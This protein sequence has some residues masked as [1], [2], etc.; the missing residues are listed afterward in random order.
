MKNAQL[1]DFTQGNITSQLVTFAWPLFLSNLLQVFYNMVDMIIV[2]RV[3]GKAGT[4]AVAVGGDISHFLAFVAM[5][6]SSAGQVLI[7]KYV[8]SRQTDKI[9]RFVGTMGGFL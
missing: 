7:A 2:G 6:F 1:R 9:G 8:G 3:L 4:S 5:G